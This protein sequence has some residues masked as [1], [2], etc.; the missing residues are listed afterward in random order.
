ME[1]PSMQFGE[2]FVKLKLNLNSVQSYYNK[3][4]EYFK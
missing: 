3:K 1:Q 2:L 4:I